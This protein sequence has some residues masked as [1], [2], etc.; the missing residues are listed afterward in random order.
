[1]LRR[2][3][4]RRVRRRDLPRCCRTRCLSC[5][6]PCSRTRLSSY[7]SG[8]N[9]CSRPGTPRPRIPMQFRASAAASEA[10]GKRLTRLQSRSVRRRSG[11]S[12]PRATICGTR[13]RLWR[14]RR[15]LS[16]TGER[17]VCERST[18]LR[19][20]EWCRGATRKVPSRLWFCRCSCFYARAAPP[21]L[22]NAREL[23]RRQPR[24]SRLESCARSA[25]IRQTR[26]W[27]ST[28]PSPRRR[29]TPLQTLSSTTPRGRTE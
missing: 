11:C 29:R 3:R 6:P 18:P 25:P 20:S 5:S 17:S 21:R 12:S 27:R 15:G 19:S 14:R 10:A 7:V 22:S 28:P 23:S 4:R 26:C 1:M 13:F 2:R 16:S 24:C 9:T 8:S